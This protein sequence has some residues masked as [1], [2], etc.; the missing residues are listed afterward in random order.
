MT[1]QD[2]TQDRLTQA[3]GASNWS[4]NN[5]TDWTDKPANAKLTTTEQHVIATIGTGL[6]L[7]FISNPLQ[8]A[9]AIRQFDKS[10]RKAL[11]SLLARGALRI[12]R[13]YC[14]DCETIIPGVQ[15]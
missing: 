3:R 5:V 14:P 12:V 8:Y 7:G 10:E 4:G 2:V 6:E 9:P 1:T 13:R 15:R 11:L